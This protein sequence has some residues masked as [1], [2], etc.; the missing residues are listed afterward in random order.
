MKL[1]FDLFP[2]IV[3]FIAYKLEDIYVATAV[4]IVA[5]GLQ[6]AWCKLRHGK[7]DKML[8]IS[9]WLFLVFGGAT[10]LLQNEAFIKWKPSILYWA[11][12][13][14]LLVS[15]VFFNKNLM[16]AMLHEKVTLPEPAWSKLNLM[17]SAFFASMGFANIY[18]AYSFS[19][20]TWVNF[21]LFGLTGIMFVFIIAQG[22]WLSKYLDEKEESN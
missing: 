15:K 2:V 14:V 10:I 5:T 6:V 20:D 19:T 3:F 17:W 1:L 4:A 12:A 16:Q 11:F 21:K 7:V 9:F 13:V 8:W 22:I 18:V